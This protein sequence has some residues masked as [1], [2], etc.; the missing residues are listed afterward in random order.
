[1]REDWLT[2]FAQDSYT[3]SGEVGYRGAPKVVELLEK[4]ADLIRY[5]REH[6]TQM[7][8]QMMLLA[9]HRRATQS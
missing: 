1:M 3:G 8:H 7:S 5:L 9:S 2:S 4:Q 6:N